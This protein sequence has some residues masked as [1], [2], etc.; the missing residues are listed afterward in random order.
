MGKLREAKLQEAFRQEISDLIQRELKDPRI[1]FVSVTAVEISGDLRHATAYVSILG[2]EEEKRASL[3]GL[4]RATGFVR[5]E[6]GRRIRLRYTPE[7]EF[8]LDDSIAYGVKLAN[9]IGQIQKEE[10]AGRDDT[11]RE[12][13][14]QE[15]HP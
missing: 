3:E 13:D 2:S 1:G 7:L 12:G 11:K 9:L 8:R 10:G 15:S 6:L 14:D 4:R 5:S